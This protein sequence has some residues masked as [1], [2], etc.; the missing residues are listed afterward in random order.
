MQFLVALLGG[1]TFGLGL[2]VSGMTD[3]NK[4][5][6]FLDLFGTWDPAL[7]F[8]MG[9]ALM[10]SVPGYFFVR[11]LHRPILSKQ[12]FMPTNTQI[13]LRLVAG[14]ALFGIGWG[15]YGYCPGPA[16][17]SIAYG[18][19]ET[20]AFLIAMV[21]GLLIPTFMRTPQK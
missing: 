21:V 10:V 13:D 16:V 19:P 3:R 20:W 2:A 5:L 15:L 12:F 9:G 17:A 14:A 8:V 6:N 18:K 1:I 4:V 7:M 11:K